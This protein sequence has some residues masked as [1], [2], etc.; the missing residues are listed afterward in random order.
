M[1]GLL[2]MPSFVA[3]RRTV[4]PS[5]SIDFA[6]VVHPTQRE[7]IT[8]PPFMRWARRL[9]PAHVE[10]VAAYAPPLALGTMRDI[11][12]PATGRTVQG[13]LLT[14]GS[15]PHQMLRRPPDFTYR[16]LQ[17][18]A[19]YAAWRG[20]RVMGLGAFTSVVGDAGETV[21]RHSP[22]AITTG[23][24]LTVVATLATA[25]TALH[26]VGRDIRAARAMIVGATGSIGAACARLLV[27]E[28]A[29]LTLVAPRAERV[30]ALAT[31]L[32]ATA[33]RTPLHTAT[34]PDAHAAACDLL[35]LATSALHDSVLPLARLSPGSVVCDVAIPSNVNATAAAARPDVLVVESGEIALPGTPNLGF[36]IGTPPGVA[37]ACLAETIVLA[38]E[39]YTGHYTLGRHISPAHV[40][41]METLMHRHG[42]RLAPLRSFGRVVTADQYATVRAATPQRVPAY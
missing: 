27:H 31:E 1:L 30:Q 6:F 8:T 25:R 21:A 28:V 11:V 5:N 34:T 26:A 40:A 33:P 14:L 7:Y 16:R 39:G 42:L 37:Y 23:N 3:H 19:R 22:L 10:Q 38:L 41:E 20:A 15:T 12:S 29:A 13:V 2:R 24:T 35:I 9:P 36:G 32:A 18:A 17:I 4:H